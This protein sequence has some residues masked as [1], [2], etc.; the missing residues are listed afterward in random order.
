MKKSY[1]LVGVLTGLLALYTTVFA[2]PKV[3]PSEPYRIIVKGKHLHGF[4]FTQKKI[5][6]QKISGLTSTEFIHGREIGGGAAVFTIK[7]QKINLMSAKQLK[8]P[9]EIVN[10]IAKKI[11]QDPDIEYAVPDR[12]VKMLEFDHQSQWD[13]F[14]PPAGVS[15]E[16]PD[17]AWEI[18]QGDP[19]IVVAVL[20]TGIAHHEDLEK[21]IVPG[22]SFV[23]YDEDNTDHGLETGYHGT[24]VAGTIAANGKILGMAPHVKIQPIQVLGDYGTGRMSGIISGIYWAAGIDVPGVPPNPTPAK[25]INMSLGGD[26]NCD[27]PTRD[28]IRQVTEQ[29]VTVVVAAGNEDNDAYFSSPANCSGVITVAATNREGKR[30]YYSNYGKFVD[31]AA[32]GGETHPDETSGILSTVK[33]GYAYYQGTSMATPHVAGIIALLYS[34][35]TL[36]T[37]E[38]AL[39]IIK[40]TATAFP[41]PYGFYS[42]VGR[43]SCGQGIINASKA[44]EEANKVHALSPLS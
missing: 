29:G 8:S 37:S 14:A 20:D 16:G 4:A 11:A 6:Q 27:W 23:N 17:G 33:D 22:F 15:L 32:P 26:G 19:N 1:L 43:Y 35:D 21:N 2:E 44:V 25:V 34:V 24:H 40:N 5:L 7:K 42:C 31:I 9:D 30:S 12:K 38:N 39:K 18:T 41:H 10:D 3:V 28:A 13:E 36:M